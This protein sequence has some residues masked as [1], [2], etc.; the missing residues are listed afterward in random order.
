M[1]GPRLGDN[2]VPP[3]VMG[4][5]SVVVDTRRRDVTTFTYDLVAFRSIDGRV[6]QI[7]DGLRP[8]HELAG[9]PA[10]SEQM[11]A[12]LMGKIMIDQDRQRHP[13]QVIAE[14]WAP[15]TDWE[16]ITPAVGSTSRPCARRSLPRS[17]SWIPAVTPAFFHR[18]KRP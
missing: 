2:Q 1:V 9:E 14:V 13:Q 4:S 8:V 10:V 17:A 5:P 3:R 12:A 18:S 11:S 16:S 7:H 6:P 15:L